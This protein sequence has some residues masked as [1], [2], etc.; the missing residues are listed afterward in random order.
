MIATNPFKFG[1]VVDDP[2]FTDRV[3]EQKEIESIL[4]SSV[5]LVIISPR[6][7]G[8]TSLVRKVVS[9]MNR[10]LIFF[11]LQLVT[12][13]Q[14]LATQILRK[15]YKV[16]PFEKIKDILKNFRI[17]PSI[18][19]NPQT[20]EVDITFQ[21]KS[22]I[23]PVL[24]DVF[25]LLNKLGSDKNK[26]IV[27]L[28]E[29]Q[30]INYLSL[31]LDK[32][33][34]AIIQHH[35]NVNYVFMGSVES[36]MREIFE[37]KKS[38]FYHF[39]QLMPLEK[40]PYNDFHIFISSGFKPL[41]DSHNEVANAILEI[42]TCH[43]YYTQQLSYNLWNKWDSQKPLQQLIQ[44]VY[45]HLIQIHD[46]DFQRL[47]QNQNHTD[48]KILLSIAN[49][50]QNLLSQANIQNLGFSSSSTLFSGLKR[51]T[52]QGFILKTDGRYQ[53]DDPFFKKWIYN[54]R[55]EN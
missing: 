16:Y 54:R 46:M 4:Q 48:K 27:V 29:F 28:D 3:K 19:L 42:T 35:Q 23:L 36:M 49:D 53:M 40:I 22:E 26:P 14:D 25:N 30:E 7:Y 55:N 41:T 10:P 15:V 44:D 34:R 50:Y 24:E 6:R 37:K 45:N 8:K 1:S 51:L 47:W 13:V 20:N 32:Q 11:D 18:N 31:N 5:H 38:P 43:P 33:L 12:D 52:S 39:G 17:V 9:R 2:F 21:P